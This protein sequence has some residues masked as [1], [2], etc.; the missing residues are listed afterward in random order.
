[1]VSNYLKEILLRFDFI[2]VI[3]RPSRDL[4]DQIIL[5]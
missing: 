5:M 1:M 2:E 3:S 4:H